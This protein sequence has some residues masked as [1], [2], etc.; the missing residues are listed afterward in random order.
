[1]VTFCT[2]SGLYL[3]VRLRPTP[4]TCSNRN[5]KFDDVLAFEMSS[6]ETENGKSAGIVN[7]R[8]GL[9]IIIMLYYYA[10]CP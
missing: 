10:A 4:P 6:Y 5:L 8:Y 7:S 9:F 1:M 2:D 3:L